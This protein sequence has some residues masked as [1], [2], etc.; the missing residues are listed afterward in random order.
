VEQ[1]SAVGDLSVLLVEQ[2]AKQALSLAS[3]A[4]VMERGKIMLEGSSGSLM[5]SDEVQR[6]YLGG[7]G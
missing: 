1:I 3:R 6:A 2:R 5:E 4:Y 7:R